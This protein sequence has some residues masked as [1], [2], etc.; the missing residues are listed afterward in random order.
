M[1]IVVID[2]RHTTPLNA[3]LNVCPRHLCHPYKPFDSYDTYL[4]IGFY[5]LFINAA[6]FV[7][8]VIQPH[9]LLFINT[10]RYTLS[11]R[12]YLFL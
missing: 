12:D 8:Y 4:C 1:S 5:L 11:V 2:I 6:L 9:I 7:C 10:L 3:E